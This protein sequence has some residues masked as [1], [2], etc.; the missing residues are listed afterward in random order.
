M[1]IY[2]RRKVVTQYKKLCRLYFEVSLKYEVTI[3]Y[4]ML[5]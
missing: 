2:L 1:F 3:Q 4:S 5:P